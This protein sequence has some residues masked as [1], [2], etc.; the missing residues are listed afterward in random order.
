[1]QNVHIILII[2]INSGNFEGVHK[3]LVLTTVRI[4][5]NRFFLFKQ[6]FTEKQDLK[7]QPAL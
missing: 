3:Y 5:Q 4:F 2:G 7:M 6:R 1:M